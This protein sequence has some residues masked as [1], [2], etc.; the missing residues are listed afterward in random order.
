MTLI[1]L[2]FLIIFLKIL[3]I[4]VGIYEWLKDDAKKKVEKQMKDF[5]ASKKPWYVLGLFLLGFL[6][7]GLLSLLFMY[8]FQIVF[9]CFVLIYLA[10]FVFVLRLIFISLDDSSTRNVMLISIVS[11]VAFY[12]VPFPW[13]AWLDFTHNYLVEILHLKYI[14]YGLNSAEVQSLQSDIASKN[15][16]ETFSSWDYFPNALDGMAASLF[17]ILIKGASIGLLKLSFFLYHVACIVLLVLLGLLAF[18]LSIWFFFN[19]ANWLHK[20]LPL[21]KQLIPLLAAII[22]LVSSLLDTISKLIKEWD[23]FLNF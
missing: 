11:L 16:Q 14:F 10:G 22:F 13:I 15:F 2:S 9:F 19:L 8:S 6:I 3:V 5:F 21:E 20:Q 23:F 7:F 4:P 18:F 12:F 1:I 17:D